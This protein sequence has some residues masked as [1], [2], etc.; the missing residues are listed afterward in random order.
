MNKENTKSSDNL[1][2]SAKSSEQYITF[3]GSDGNL[4][5]GIIGLYG[6]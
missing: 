5:V 1:D 3:P 4:G 6:C 2:K